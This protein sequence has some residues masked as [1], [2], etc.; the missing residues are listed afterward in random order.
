[1]RLRLDHLILR[2]AEPER[3]LAELARRSGAPVLAEVEPLVGGVS[4]GIARAGSVD[5]EVLKLGETPPHPLGYGVGLVADVPLM[6]A[7]GELR[8]LGFPVSAPARGIAGEGT[9]RRRWRAAHVHGLLPNPFPA[10]ASTRRPGVRDRMTGAAA[11][12]LGRIPALARAGMSEAGDSMVVLTEYD[13]DVAAWRSTA[14]GGPEVA[15][16]ELGA[17]GSRSAWERLPLDGDVA[18]DV[19]DDGPAGLT[20]VLFAGARRRPFSLGAVRFEWLSGG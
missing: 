14:T 16:V 15:R 20:R 18:L 12:T 3:T 5:L 4:S 2:T 8:A 19:R 6:Q 17:A 1:V 9:E 11:G 13:F 10:P 7:V